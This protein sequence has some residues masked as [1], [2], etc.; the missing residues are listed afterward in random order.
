MCICKGAFHLSELAVRTIT[1]PVSFFFAS[2]PSAL[3]HTIQDLTDLAGE[4]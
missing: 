2:K 3:V 4:F 1:G